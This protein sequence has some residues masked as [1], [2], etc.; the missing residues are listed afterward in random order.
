M[1]KQEATYYKKELHRLR[2]AT[3]L[4]ADLVRSMLRNSLRKVA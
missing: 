1:D 2:N 4:Y 3:H